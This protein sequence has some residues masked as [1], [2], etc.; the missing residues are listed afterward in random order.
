MLYCCPTRRPVAICVSPS[1]QLSGEVSGFWILR[2][3]TEP[4]AIVLGGAESHHVGFDG[5]LEACRRHEQRD[6]HAEPGFRQYEAVNEPQAA[7][8]DDNTAKLNESLEVHE[9]N[10]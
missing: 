7:D 6:H 8:C 5:R 1:K 2:P 3:G 4:S 10:P 9:I